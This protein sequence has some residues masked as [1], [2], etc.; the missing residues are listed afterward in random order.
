[1]T[2]CPK[3]K[4]E[5]REGFNTCSDCGS[6]LVETLD[7]NAKSNIETVGNGNN[8][9]W[10]HLIGCEDDQEAD[11]IKSFL[12]EEN[13]L[14]V[15][16][17]SGASEYL[18]ITMGMAKLGVDLYVKESQLDEAIKIINAII[19][20]EHKVNKEL[21]EKSFE[22][23]H[24]NKPKKRLLIMVIIYLI[25]VLCVLIISNWSTVKL[26]FQ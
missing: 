12:S 25:P 22:K 9:E 16:N 8:E 20:P 7:L 13:I 26:L 15:R 3:C 1:M 17:Y 21:S 24:M 23:I 10:L 4:T 18:K 19:R 2:W 5:Y 6:S 11:I 14:T